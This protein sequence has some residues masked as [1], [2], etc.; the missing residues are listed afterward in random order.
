MPIKNIYWLIDKKH[1][2]ITKT[3]KKIDFTSVHAQTPLQCYAKVQL[4][5]KNFKFP[6]HYQ[7]III[8][9]ALW[10][11]NSITKALHRRNSSI[12]LQLFTFNSHSTKILFFLS[13]HTKKA[14]RV[15]RQTIKYKDF[16]RVK[17]FN[18]EIYGFW[19]TRALRNDPMKTQVRKSNENERKIYGVE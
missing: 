13:P 3:K 10:S 5:N 11:R 17:A 6:L 4:K 12:Q 18:G 2:L 1:A 19:M 9:S 16:L 8:N 7:N 15:K 14:N